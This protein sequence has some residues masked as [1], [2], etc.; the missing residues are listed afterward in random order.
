[1]DEV[2]F[3][4]RGSLGLVTLNRPRALNALTLDMIHEMTRQLGAWTRDP[5]VAAVLIRG[6]G[7]KAFCA[8]GDIRALVQP[9][10]AAYIEGFF[11]DEYCLDRMIFRYPKP[12]I[13]LINGIAMG[14]GVGVSVNGAHRIATEATLFAMP[15]TGIGMFPDVGGSWFLPRCPGEIGIYLGLT[16]AR[17]GAADC[18]YAGIADV[19]V[20]DGA[21]PEMIDRLAAGEPTALVLRDLAVEPGPAPL[22]RNREAVDRCFAGDSVEAIMAAL[23]EE[24][25]DWAARTLEALETKSPLALKVALRQLRKGRALDFEGCMAMEYR[26][27]QRVVPGHD[28]REGVRA[29]VVDKDRSPKWDPPTLAAVGEETVAAC[30][31]PLGDRELRFAA[32]PDGDGGGVE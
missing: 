8:G 24:G 32:P 15:E 14:G 27:S 19:Q 31:A 16:G 6:A 13:A 20:G 1:M 7:D 9:D 25:G 22:A 12:Y 26:L 23:R 28:F 10:N 2:L 11:A 17:L 29:A 5:A 21:E 4:T 3:E 18:L 30:F